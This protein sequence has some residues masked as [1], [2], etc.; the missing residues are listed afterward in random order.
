MSGFKGPPGLPGPKV[1]FNL[2]PATCIHVCLY[3]NNIVYVGILFSIISVT[4][5]IISVCI[6]YM[7]MYYS[8]KGFIYFNKYYNLHYRAKWVTLVDL[9]L[10]EKLVQR[11]VTVKSAEAGHHFILLIYYYY[12]VN[13]TV[14]IG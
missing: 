2:H 6:M 12:S 8:V 3:Y 4:S 7:Y 5:K 11:S 13:T 1:I 9:G 14:C 10:K